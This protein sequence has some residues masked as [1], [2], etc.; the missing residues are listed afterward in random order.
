MIFVKGY[1]QMCNNIL[2]YAHAYVWGKENNVKV[3]SMRF[4]YKYRYFEVCNY[5]YH[6]W[7]VYLFAKMLIKLQLIKCFFLDEPT[8]VTPDVLAELKRHRMVAIDGWQFRFPELFMKYRTEIKD[9]FAFKSLVLNKIKSLLEEHT[10]ADGTDVRL[11]VHIRRGDYKVWMGGKY[12]FNDDVYIEH[13][14][15]FLD[16]FPDKKVSVF[17]CTNDRNLN[18]NCY[19]EALGLKS[20]YCPKGNEAED[21]CLLSQCDYIIGV[22][23]TFSLMAAFYN[24]RPIY[25]I[26]DKNAPLQLSNFSSFEKL[27]MTV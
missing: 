13:I 17:I 25:W 15:Q 21:L 9:M 19:R 4:A 14:R 5:K 8:D 2:Q 11:A 27:F 1:G 6:R 7:P 24:N 23:S 16:N 22:K 3:V 20:I 18:V 10:K 12:F 26:M